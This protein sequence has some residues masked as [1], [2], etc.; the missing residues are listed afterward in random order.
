ML[1]NSRIKKNKIKE[2]N[3][4]PLPG[5]GIL[6]LNTDSNVFFS[7]MKENYRNNCLM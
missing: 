5:K 1:R 2:K 6:F 7:K 4:I 3:K